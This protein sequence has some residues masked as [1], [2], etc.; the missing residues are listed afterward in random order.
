MIIKKV[1]VNDAT[2]NRLMDFLKNHPKTQLV[3]ANLLMGRKHS[4]NCVQQVL[5]AFAQGRNLSKSEELELI[6]VISGE[7]QILKALEIA[8]PDKE[9]AFISWN[10]KDIWSDFI[11]EFDVE[12]R[13][14]EE[15]SDLSAI[16]KSST[17][18]IQ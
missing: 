4:I 12:E 5:K 2:H 18:W 15:S 6:L 9:I 17:F 1:L 3:K 7:R 14:I 8:K 11:K 16:E 13:E 10:E